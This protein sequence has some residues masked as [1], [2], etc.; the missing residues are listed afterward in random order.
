MKKVTI[1]V[2]GDKSIS[3]RAVLFGALAR[4]TTCANGA[5]QAD[6]VRRTLQ[7]VEQLGAEVVDSGESLLIRGAPWKSVEEIDC[8]NSGTTARMLLGALSARANATLVGDESL[9]KRPMGRVTEPLAQMGALFSGGSTLPLQVHWSELQGIRHEAKVASAQVKSAVLLAGLAANGPT[10]YV[11]AVGTRD[12]SERMLRGL[13]ANIKVETTDF[14]QEVQIW[15]GAL[16]GTEIDV[17]GDISSAAFWMVAA[18][19]HGGSELLLSGVGINP[20]RTGVIDVL[21]RM[22]CRITVE[23][24]GGIE[25]MADILVQGGE[26]R[27]TVIQGS[28]IPR[29]IDE[30]PVIAICAAFAEGETV[31]RDAAELRVKE[32]DRVETVVQGLRHMGVEAEARP[33]GFVVF[34]GG[35]RRASEIVQTRGDHRIAM[36]FS[37]AG[38]RVPVTVSETASIQTS[39]PGFLAELERLRA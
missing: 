17:P 22:G 13:G 23:P 10:T 3:H 9:R 32:S 27:G 31:V 21:R 6:D 24:L 25:P 20:S 19:I 39:Y 34:G 4:G 18:A 28:E 26:L 16:T 30:L 38:L 7:A 1:Q 29:L 2:P 11:E 37:V 8:G 35:A 33:D 5:L 15:P 36:A 14:G 12:H